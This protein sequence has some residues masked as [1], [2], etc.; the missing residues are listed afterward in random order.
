M[1]VRGGVGSDFMPGLV[2]GC[3]AFRM[4]FSPG[5]G[6]KKGC[7]YMIRGKY[8][9]DFTGVLVAERAVEGERSRLFRFSALCVRLF[10]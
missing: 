7:F 1:L 3:E 9:E 2:Y 4:I 5:S 10:V 6:D 8:T